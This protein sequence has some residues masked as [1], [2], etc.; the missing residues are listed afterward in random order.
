MPKLT[1]S[2]YSSYAHPFSFNTPHT[3]NLI[4][5]LHANLP[6]F[7][8]SFL[9]PNPNSKPKPKPKPNPHSRI[10]WTGKSTYIST[11]MCF[12][13]ASSYPPFV[14]FIQDISRQL[15][16]EARKVVQTFY[17]HVYFTSLCREW[18]W[19]PSP[20]PPVHFPAW[21]VEQYDGRECVEL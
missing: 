14:P 19:S 16:E 18:K 15:L 7:S 8:F 6:S 5:I 1:L 13:N 21:L 20:P 17:T 2:Q 12:P 4:L 11:M 9:S 10:L 3:P